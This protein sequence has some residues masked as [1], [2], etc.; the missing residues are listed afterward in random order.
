MQR[1]VLLVFEE[2]D[3]LVSVPEMCSMLKIGRNKAYNLLKSG[4]IKVFRMG[5]TW[6]ISKQAVIQY[7][8]ENSKI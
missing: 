7:I 3:E 4:E 2:Y 6:K 1:R 8:T 5:H